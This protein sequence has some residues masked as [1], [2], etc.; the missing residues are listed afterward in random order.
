MIKLL[1]TIALSVFLIMGT[2]SFANA[3][4][5]C[6]CADGHSHKESTKMKPCEKCM[7][8]KTSGKKEPCTKCA[9][10]EKSYQDKK[11]SKKHAMKNYSSKNTAGTT[12]VDR[13]NVGSLTIQSGKTDNANYN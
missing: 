6:G 1:S 9:E 2:S 12:I 10:S 3:C 5:T 4:A 8:S 11:H 13:S 7:E